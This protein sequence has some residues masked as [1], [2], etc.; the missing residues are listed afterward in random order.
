MNMIAKVSTGKASL[1]TSYWLICFPIGF[2]VNLA[3]K[4]GAGGEQLLLMLLIPFLWSLYGVWR[5][6]FNVRYRVWGY[7]A[8]GL[9]IVNVLIVF[10]AFFASFANEIRKPQ[11]DQSTTPVNQSNSGNMMRS[12]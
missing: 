11:L 6:A 12:L 7:L 1:M 5:C 2:V 3:D 8:R 4:A 10:V 9:M